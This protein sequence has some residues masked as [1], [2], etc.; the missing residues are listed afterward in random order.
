MNGIILAMGVVVVLAGALRWVRVRRISR[1]EDRRWYTDDQIWWAQL[2]AA[3]PTT[4]AA[5]AP[6]ER[7]THVGLATPYGSA[8][9]ATRSA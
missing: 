8:W 6:T 9:S 2:R 3:V 4:P 7:V 5:A 1:E